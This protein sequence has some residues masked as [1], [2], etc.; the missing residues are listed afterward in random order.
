MSGLL[1]RALADGRNRTIAFAAAFAAIAYIQPVAYRR[2]YPTLADRLGFARSFGSNLALRLFYGVPHRLVTIG[3]YTAWRVAGLMTLFAGVWGALAAVR[4]TRA[5]EEAGR[6]ELVLAL[7]ASRPATFAAALGAGLVGCVALWLAT[8]AGLVAAGLPAPGS[9]Y[10]ALATVC[11]AVVFLA[12]G[13]LAGQVAATR[14]VALELSLAAL[15]LALAAR[16]AADTV[17]GL[18]WLRW[19][20][21]LGWAENLRPFGATDPAA[22][23]PVVGA[24]AAGSALALTLWRRRDVGRGALAA[25]DRRAPRTRLL[26]A[27]MAQALRGETGSLTVWLAGVGAFALIL[28]IV[29]KA[30]KAAGISLSLR[31][32]LARLGYAS[33]LTPR[34]Y[35]SFSFQFF[36]VIVALFACAQISATAAE[37]TGG[38]LETLLTQPVSRGRWLAGRLTLALAGAAA[39]SLTAGIMSWAGATAA[40]VAIGPLTLIEAGANCLPTAVLFGGLA[41]L[42]FGAAPRV[43]GPV[44][45]GLVALAFLWDLFG[46]LLG[47]PS[48]LVELSPLRHVGLVPAQA[49]RPIA[50]LVMVTAGIACA[51]AGAALLGRRDIGGA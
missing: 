10:L 33:I 50:A 46:A 24:S 36:V 47:A 23:I 45:Y 51:F 49:F 13:A 16:V 31:R 11:P 35:L 19:A 43:A 7:G 5:E 44:A 25:R 20:T 15:A 39:L 22:L 6:S 29:S 3:G 48:W 41:A 12:A 26:S 1:R 30:I 9:A 32:E 14:R 21:P 28:G 8:L 4:A 37:E 2:T 27:P 40:G 18:G 17:S 38:H 42:V 34:G